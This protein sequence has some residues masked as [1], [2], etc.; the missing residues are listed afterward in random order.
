M[1]LS[2]ISIFALLP[3]TLV[4]LAL[5]IYLGGPTPPAPMDS[6]ND[7]FRSVDMADLPPLSRYTAADGTPLAY[8]KYVPAGAAIGSVTLIHGSSASSNSMHPLAKVLMK[9]GY[10]V[11]SLDMRGHGASGTRGHIAYVGQLEDDLA[12]FARSVRPVA[13][14]TLA[15]FS[16]GGGFVLRVA[17]SEYQSLFDSYLLLSPF[18]SQDAPTYKPQAGGWVS[19][20]VPRIV[21]LTLLNMAGVSAFNDL[22][23]TAFALNENAR[24]FLTP[25]YDYNLA[26]NFRP[27]RDYEANLRNVSRPTAVVA[28][29]ADEAFH[30]NQLASVIRAAGKSWPVELLPNIGHIPLILDTT[31]ISTIARHVQKLQRG[32]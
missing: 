17:G 28:G 22:P 11:F 4:A 29:A 21:G 27:Q 18:L 15:G 24:Q 7:P 12:A 8:R 3:A 2:T 5:S 26:M 20:G 6:I 13:P 14:S 30:T 23:V 32:D 9:A 19:V 16:A 25:E 10:Q 31:A 1:K